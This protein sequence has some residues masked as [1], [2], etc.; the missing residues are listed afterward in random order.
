MTAPIA[1]FTTGFLS[2]YTLPFS[3]IN[4]NTPTSWIWD[5]DDIA[6]GG[7]NSSFLQNPTHTFTQNGLYNVKLTVSNLDGSD[8]I[9]HSIQI[10]V[11]E[12]IPP[13]EKLTFEDRYERPNRNSSVVVD[14]NGRKI[15][16]YHKNLISG[17]NIGGLV[18]NPSGF[19]LDIESG[20]GLIG[21][22]GNVTWVTTNIIAAPSLFQ[23]VYVRLPI[24]GSVGTIE[25]SS[26]INMT[27]TKDVIFLAFIFAGSVGITRIINI[28]TNGNYIYV[29]RQK[30][31][32]FGG[33]LWDDY[34]DILNSGEQPNAMIHNGIIYL[35]Y[36]KNTISYLRTIEIGNE[37]EAWS[38][39]PDYK[40]QSTVFIPDDFFH[41]LSLES[42]GLS[43][44]SDMHFLGGVFNFDHKL[45][46]FNNRLVP[47]L[48]SKLHVFL[49]PVHMIVNSPITYLDIHF[50]E[51]YDT[52]NETLL[53][54]IPYN[55]V[56]T[57]LDLTSLIPTLE[58]RIVYLGWRGTLSVYSKGT[59]T[60]NFTYQKEERLKVV[61]FSNS[62]QEIFGIITKVDTRDVIKSGL[63]SSGL[64]S[65]KK[66]LLT[67]ETKKSF[68]SD[69]T[70]T[71]RTAIQAS[72]LPSDIVSEFFIQDLSILSDNT[73]TSRTAIQSS[74]LSSK[75]LII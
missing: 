43:I 67:F 3:S 1:D 6:S 28:E 49:S 25:I 33:W 47:P 2:G 27:L 59:P 21:I 8:S 52:D 65:D 15:V 71:T 57:W 58:G 73:I 12:L 45:Y 48:N 16:F 26:D 4:V 34:E 9:I 46:G 66:I 37:L 40:E 30:P 74:G 39:K 63:I 54:S 19:N 64:N 24:S 50:F 11:P 31:D 18:T 41:E 44:I 53:L 69:N 56:G 17:K 36:I 13:S 29:R 20:S 61:G 51:I 55:N 5:F 7:N 72:G 32:G 38:F 60:F 68:E 42:S 14:S 70:I 10:A 22:S 62:N 23:L 35:S 75:S